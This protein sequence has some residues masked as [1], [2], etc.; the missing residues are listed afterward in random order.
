[1]AEDRDDS[2]R[3][4]EP[5]Q[6]RLDEALKKGDV[7]K[8]MELATFVMIAGGTLALT[9]FAQSAARRFAADFTVF[10]ENPAQ[11]S[12]D[13]GGAAALLQKSIYEFFAI[14]G[15]AAGLMLL[16]A[17]GG[18]LLQHRPMFSAAKLKPDLSKLSLVAGFKRL[19]GLD[20]LI[21]LIKGV[22][23]ILLVGTASFLAVWPERSRLASALDMNPAGVAT[24]ALALIG[25][26]LLASLIVLAAIAAFDYLYQRQRFMARHRMTRQELKDEVKQSEGDPQIKAR[27]RQIRLERSKKRMIA[28]VPQASVVVVNPTHYAVALKYESG[29]MRAPVCVAKGIDHLALTIRKV[30]EEHAVP[31]VENPPLARALYAAVELDEEVPPE[32]YKAVAH[33]IGYVMRLA[34]KNSFWRN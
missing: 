16:A 25:K 20:G 30:A 31:V 15:P 21:N 5:T 13:S 8:S 14:V 23:K 11:L 18:H 9:L 27:I 26:V 32:H 12:L 6:K 29:K 33:I 1:V 4:E 28:A 3:T 22:A 2:Q 19:F 34:N 7:V 17:L 24:L 10:L